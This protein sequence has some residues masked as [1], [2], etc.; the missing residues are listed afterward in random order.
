MIVDLR[1]VSRAPLTLIGGLPRRLYRECDAVRDLSQLARVA[2]GR[3]LAPAPDAIEQALQPL[4]DRGLLLR[5]GSRY[6]ALAIP[7]GESTPSAATRR[8]FSSLIRRI[9]AAQGDRWIV[10]TTDAKS[11]PGVRRKRSR[12]RVPRLAA[13]RF[14]VDA[15]GRL[16]IQASDH[17]QRRK[18]S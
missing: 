11:A 12:G 5:E 13:S 9:G 18:E 10:P 3:G 1:P 8:R 6:L 17:P 7:I 2:S 15:Q 4:V 14:S 16:V